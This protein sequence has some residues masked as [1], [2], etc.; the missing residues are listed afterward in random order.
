MRISESSVRVV[1]PVGK[2]MGLSGER[3][4]VTHLPGVPLVSRDVDS[5]RKIRASAPAMRGKMRC[6]LILC[7]CLFI[8]WLGRD[9]LCGSFIYAHKLCLS[10][11]VSL[12]AYCRRSHRVHRLIAV[13]SGALVDTVD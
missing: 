10:F 1:I 5:E 2:E 11:S 8:F 7:P 4:S 12:I 6:L 3:C 9:Y 13:E